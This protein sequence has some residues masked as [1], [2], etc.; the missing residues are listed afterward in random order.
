MINL[1]TL[2]KIDPE[3]NELTDEELEN[4]RKEFYEFGEILF[5]DWYEQKFGSKFP[6]GS[7]T[8]KYEEHTI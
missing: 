5:D 7:L 1:N 8:I 2:R 6:L 3:V 4:T